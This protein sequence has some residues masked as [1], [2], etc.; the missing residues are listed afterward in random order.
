MHINSVV[1]SELVYKLQVGMQQV[2]G[3][4]GSQQVQAGISDGGWRG[5]T[6]QQNIPNVLQ[7]RI[8]QPKGEP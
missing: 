3:R 1:V 5:A 4:A 7:S 8:P 6:K 2:H